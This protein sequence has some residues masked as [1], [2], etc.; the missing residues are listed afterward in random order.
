MEKQIQQMHFSPPLAVTPLPARPPL[1]ENWEPVGLTQD[2][3]DMEGTIYT[4]SIMNHM[5]I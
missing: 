3:E 1:V 4:E 5:I 2:G